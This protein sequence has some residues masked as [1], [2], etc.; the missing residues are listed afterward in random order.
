MGWMVEYD[1]PSVVFYTVI[2]LHWQNRME[3]NIWSPTS[4]RMVE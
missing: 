1:N 4:H 3:N 2:I